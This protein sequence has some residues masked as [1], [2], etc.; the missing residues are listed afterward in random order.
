[1]KHKLLNKLL[2]LALLTLGGV[3]NPA[4]ATE[5]PVYSLTFSKLTS[6]TNYSSYTAAHDFTCSEKEWSVTGNQSLGAY[7]RVGGKHTTALDRTITSSET[8]VNK[9]IYK[10]II[11]HTGVSNGRSSSLTVNSITVEGSTSSDF[12]SSV[13]Y[14]T[15]S[16]PSVG[17]SGSLTFEPDDVWAA[18][19]YFRIKVNCQITGSNNCGLNITSVNF[20]EQL[21]PEIS[22]D[23]VN[24]AADV[25]AGNISYGITNPDGSSLTAAKKSGDWLTV[26]AVDAV[27]NKVAF[28]ATENTGSARAA[29]VT[30]TYGDVTK[31]VTIT[32][33]AAVAKY[34]VT[35]VSAPS[36]GTLVVK[37]EETTVS[38]GSEVSDGTE[39]TIIA[40][41]DDRY[42]LS[43]WQYKEAGDADWTDGVGTSFTI[44]GKAVAFQAIFE[45]KTYYNVTYSVNGATNVVEY[46]KDA[47]ISFAAPASSSI[48]TGYTFKGWRTAT[49]SLTDTDP[50]D[51]VTEATSSS[52]ITYYAVM[53]IG[54][55]GT[56]TLTKMGSSD[57]F[58][59]DDKVVIVAQVSSSYYAIYQETT[60][61]SYVNK[62]SFDN[63]AAS[64]AA[65]D[66]KWLTVSAGA[67][68]GKWKLGDS[69]NGYIYN[70]SSNNL[71]ADTSHSTDFTLTW[72]S[73]QS[74][75][76][77][78]GNDRWLSYRNDLTNEFYRMGG[79]T[80]SDPS[81][82]A[83]FDIYKYVPASTTYN[84]FCTSVTTIPVK[85]GDASYA[86]FA[87]N[88]PLDFT[89]SDIKAYIA[90][91]KADYSGVKFYQVE[92]VPANTGVLLYK[93]G[94]TAESI[95]VLDGDADAT[96]D[97]VFK[98][99]TGTAVA[100][101]DT[102]NDNLH[103]YILNK[104]GGV[105][106]FYRA[107]G[108]T[109]ATNRAYIQID[110]SKS[111]SVK[112]FISL[113]GFDDDA[114]SINEE[115]RIKNEESSEGAIYNL[116]GQRI[117]KM[118][119]GINIINGKK[120]LR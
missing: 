84:S 80:S 68:S 59:A 2:T 115:L 39:L 61:T 9:K 76:T 14:K 89:D 17:S 117:S 10:I 98:V 12:S 35:Y 103:N 91:G 37:R 88:V 74:K 24:I 104:V 32:Q 97:N 7:V 106:G 44:D 109:V 50:D 119:K 102:E 113:P 46:E 75:F 28:T 99:G 118:Q 30:L 38:S 90:K 58:T 29:V 87:C 114:D 64:V 78:V 55:I 56:P 57:T 85:V 116:A 81:G 79:A 82:T 100:S 83:Y 42:K 49:L 71:T 120:V 73:T 48:P 16:S 20:Y 96:T 69:T 86:T 26:G 45:A 23:D 6:G 66:K 15:L 108:Q 93:S 3:I 110:E 22:A 5:T 34:A 77:L 21:A 95:P 11:N 67:S 60:N 25:L 112:E 52:N 40:T 33:A 94:G 101:V 13:I 62:Y 27:N 47:D 105:V 4:W 51:Y 70:G 41:P 53:A 54:A 43:K 36:N 107:A 111:Y 1:M 63:N 31:D 65:D 18:N 72:N 8:I 19:S 92:K